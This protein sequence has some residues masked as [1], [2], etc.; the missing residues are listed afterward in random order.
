MSEMK[1]SKKSNTFQPS[2]QNVQKL[3]YHLIRISSVKMTRK[4]LSLAWR[5][6]EC[7]FSLFCFEI[8]VFFLR[9]PEERVRVVFGSVVFF[10]CE[11]SA[12]GGGSPVE[13]V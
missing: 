12:G 4:I 3:L 6:L 2:F 11:G 10:R 9:K 13:R 7:L 1:T 8:F 5:T